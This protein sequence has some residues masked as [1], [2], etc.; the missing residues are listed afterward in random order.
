ML[1]CMNSAVF[2]GKRSGTADL[3]GLFMALSQDDALVYAVEA[4]RLDS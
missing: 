1:I 2:K 3:C 4:A